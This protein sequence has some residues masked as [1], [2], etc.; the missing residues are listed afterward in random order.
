[1]FNP[2]SLRHRCFKT[3]INL[4][5]IIRGDEDKVKDLSLVKNFDYHP[6]VL[7]NY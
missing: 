2:T 1:M 4:Y 7:E 6:E 5:K 3:F